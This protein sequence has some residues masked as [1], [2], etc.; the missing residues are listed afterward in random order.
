MEKLKNIREDKEK[1]EK[2]RKLERLMADYEACKDAS[3]V[4]RIEEFKHWVTFKRISNVRIDGDCVKCIVH[5]EVNV[6]LR[7]DRP[8]Q[9]K[10]KEFSYGV[11]YSLNKGSGFNSQGFIQN[12]KPCTE[13]EFLAAK[14]FADKNLKIF[15][16]YFK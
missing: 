4:V 14:E 9:I 8:V 11:R 3:Y 12:D 16:K 2:Q 6:N 5:E 10:E 7:E 13:E 1:A 15:K